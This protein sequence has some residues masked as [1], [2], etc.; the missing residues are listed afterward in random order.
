MHES[1]KWTLVLFKKY[2][3]D[4]YCILSPGILQYP[5][6]STIK[7][8]LQKYLLDFPD[9]PVIKNPPA[10]AGDGGLI[11]GLGRSHMLQNN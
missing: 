2:L 3:S 1:E 4:G 11:P 9:G 5:N 6:F 8:S 7:S 10:N